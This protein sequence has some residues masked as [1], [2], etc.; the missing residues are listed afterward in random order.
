[1]SRLARGFLFVTGVGILTLVLVLLI[2]DRAIMP[3][4]VEVAKVR[5]PDLRQL[6]LDK[7]GRRLENRGLRLAVRDS[8]FQEVLARG[9][10]VDQTPTTGQRIKQGRRVFVDVSKG[11]RQFPVP[12]LKQK[13][14]RQAEILL[15]D[16]DLRLG[17]W[18]YTSSSSVPRDATVTQV[19]R[20]GVP[21]K[22]NGRVDLEISSGPPD[23]LK[24]VPKV[25]GLLINV[26]EDSL[27]KY[28]MDMG[29]I[30]ER[31][32]NRRPAG[33][34]LRQRPAAGSRARRL[35]RVDVVI[36]AHEKLVRTDSMTTQQP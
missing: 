4:I 11:P 15:K 24:K 3:S 8:L 34:V 32:D 29:R 35:T 21:M 26:V 6:P 31:I 1:M 10:V 36:T 30:D 2:L 28:E 20:P 25:V 22:R 9:T 27:E 14:L 13:S 33:V 16:A 12:N 23:A 18:R 19:P 17:S 7:A 5:V